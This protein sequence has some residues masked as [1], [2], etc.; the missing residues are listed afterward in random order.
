MTPVASVPRGLTEWKSNSQLYTWTQIISC[1]RLNTVHRQGLTLSFTLRDI[2]PGRQGH[3]NTK[4]FP[5]DYKTPQ[6]SYT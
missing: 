4:K 1:E 3:I 5:Q 6:L 2:W